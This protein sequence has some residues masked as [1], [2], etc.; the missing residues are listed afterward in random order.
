VCFI[1]TEVANLQDGKCKAVQGLDSRRQGV[2]QASCGISSLNVQGAEINGKKKSKKKVGHLQDGGREA[3]Q[4][5]LERD[6]GVDEALFEEVGLGVLYAE[7]VA[8][9]VGQLLNLVAHVRVCKAIAGH[10][11]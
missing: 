8:H 6:E 10:C 1:G 3:V 4:G 5:V 7:K 11:D 2:H 9:R